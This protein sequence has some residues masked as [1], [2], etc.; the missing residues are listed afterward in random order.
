[1]LELSN[2]VRKY[3]HIRIFRKYTFQRQGPLNFAKT[4]HFLAK[5]VPL[6]KAI[7]WELC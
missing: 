4:Q 5:I 2:L 6:L 7:L 1:M 3:T